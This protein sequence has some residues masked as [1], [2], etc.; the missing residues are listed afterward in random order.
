MLYSVNQI[1]AKLLL[2]FAQ[3]AWIDNNPAVDLADHQRYLMMHDLYIKARSYSL[4][5]KVAFWFALLLGIAV[6]VWPSFAVIS[7]DFGWQKE[8]LKSAIV[9]TT[10]TAFAGLAFAIYAHYKKRQVYI[11][12]LMRSI[13][14]APE[15]D[16]SMLDR[17]L[18]EM[19]RIDSG[20]GFAQALAK[21]K[22]EKESDE[23]K[24]EAKHEAAKAKR[25]PAASNVKKLTEEG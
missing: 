1:S 18:K 2:D 20:F 17:V 8:F 15:W 25:V 3:K 5:N 13:V 12:N 6:V 16:N 4:I 10:V 9:Q 24:H 23:V 21:T 7:Q 22:T 14:Y 11:E 19:E